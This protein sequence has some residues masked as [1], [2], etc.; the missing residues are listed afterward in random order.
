MM[1]SANLNVSL[2]KDIMMPK[3][4]LLKN[5]T[6]KKMTPEK[7]RK[8]KFAIWDYY[9]KKNQSTSSSTKPKIKF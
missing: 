5:S 6:S 3:S 8:Q 2:M 1:N 4:P 9:K 7:R